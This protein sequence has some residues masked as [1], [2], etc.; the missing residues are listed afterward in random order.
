MNMSN[1]SNMSL[2]LARTLSHV[3]IAEQFAEPFKK[4][5]ANGDTIL[6]NYFIRDSQIVFS[7]LKNNQGNWMNYTE[8]LSLCDFLKLKW[9]YN[10]CPNKI[11]DF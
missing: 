10:V 5:G 9:T 4:T 7:Y 2:Q 8:N 11:G 1:M 3:H 6:N